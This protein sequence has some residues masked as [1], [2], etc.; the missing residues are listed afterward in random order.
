MK[1]RLFE[2]RR[3]KAQIK[4]VQNASRNNKH[5][6]SLNYLDSIMHEKHDSQSMTSVHMIQVV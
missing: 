2:V 5:H 1:V 6:A 4:P 3:G